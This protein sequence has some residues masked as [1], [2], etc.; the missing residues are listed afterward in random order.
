MALLVCGALVVAPG[1]AGAWRS[2]LPGIGRARGV[3]VSKG[4][5]IAAGEM[6]VES[7]N[8]F[9]VSSFDVTTGQ[10]VW[11][12][13]VAPGSA[14]GILVDAAGD[15]LVGGLLGEKGGA[16][17]VK[18]DDVTGNEIWRFRVPRSL[19]FPERSVAWGRA[20]NGDAI[21]AI[22]RTSVG[23]D[24]VRT[25]VYRVAS[26][27][28]QVVWRKNLGR[29]VAVAL[30][31]DSKGDVL[32]AAAEKAAG[33][34]AGAPGPQDPVRVMKLDR[35]SGSVLW[36]SYPGMR[37]QDVQIA[38]AS[39]DQV[40]VAGRADLD[41][42][43]TV[44]MLG[45]IDGVSRW[46]AELGYG[47]GVLLRAAATGDVAVALNL[48]GPLTGTEVS[49]LAASD[50]TARWSRTVASGSGE[51]CGSSAFFVGAAG[52]PVLGGC[53][54]AAPATAFRFELTGLDGKTGVIR[55]Q[56]GIDGLAFDAVTDSMPVLG[57]SDA[58]NGNLA[59]VG[60][61]AD[62]VDAP[63]FT[64]VEWN[65]DRG[66][67][68]LDPAD[69]R[70][71]NAIGS[72]GRNY[73]FTRLQFV[74][75]CFDSINAGTLDLGFDECNL[76]PGF[77]IKLA[78]LTAR[79]V[80]SIRSECAGPELPEG[81]SCGTTLYELLEE[82]KASGQ[83]GCLLDSDDDVGNEVA[84]AVYRRR[85]RV[86]EPAA[87]RKCQAAIGTAGRRFFDDVMD[88]AVICRTRGAA[89]LSECIGTDAFEA[90]IKDSALSQRKVINSNCSTNGIIA[91]TGTC[92][93]TLDGLIASSG[94]SG[95]LL[96]A[97]RA[98]AIRSARVHD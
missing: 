64:V 78:R 70:C 45:R 79:T 11:R 9:S 94:T 27:N 75:T 86:D 48:A 91:A 5:V 15:L 34:T 65:D 67:D 52:D 18:L 95:C 80:A 17:I 89:D 92:A 39:D 57:I 14:T 13:D 7:E 23:S 35:A 38:I 69:R 6:A 8:A 43:A 97:S 28:G 77:K 68:L 31:L 36:G 88:A 10:L 82:P 30:A 85:I 66:D 61:T 93:S 21:L 25:M 22:G 44:V 16:G 50:G 55:W 87:I 62:G 83:V 90:P 56:R 42:A 73:V 4:R 74:E 2:S 84:A 96:E 29:R 46:R 1:V 53:A 3:V 12:K 71:R 33:P 24:K 54:A 51:P 60:A 49:R 98:G 58:G 41:A 47:A 26:S 19:V 63:A 20:L 40:A 32:V 37:A 76:D 81:V 72:A 59:A